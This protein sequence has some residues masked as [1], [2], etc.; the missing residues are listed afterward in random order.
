MLDDD[1]TQSAIRF[2]IWLDR[3]LD[4][5]DEQVR[6]ALLYAL[7]GVLAAQYPN[8]AWPGFF[9]TKRRTYGGA[10]VKAA[11]LPA[12][13][14]RTWVKPAGGPYYILNDNLMR[15]T[16]HVLLLAGRHFDDQAY[17]DAAMRGGEFLLNAQ[18][19]E[20][21]RGWA[22]IYDGDMHP[23]WGRQFEPPAV[24]SLESAG[25]VSALLQLYRRTGDTRFLDAAKSAGAW[26]GAG[27]KSRKATGRGSMSL[28]TNRP[29]YIDA[30]DQLTYDPG[31]LRHGYTFTNKWDI[32]EVLD[33]LTAVAKGE[34]VPGATVL[35][36][37]RGSLSRERRA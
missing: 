10:P 14:S 36:V 19:P 35:A 29:I 11:S 4:G 21:Q 26:L 30:N 24:A 20:P 6:E 3:A 22:Q 13:W 34:P 15:D 33:E 32:P 27:T 2:L 7:N 25:A 16:V 37:G 28:R 9:E 12:E 18:L 8:G 1:T 23:V 5:K 17:L 31:N